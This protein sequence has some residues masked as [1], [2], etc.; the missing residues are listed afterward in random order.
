MLSIATPLWR[1]QEGFL[2]SAE[3]VLIATITILSMV[4]G[5]SEIAHGV[6]QELED[7]GTAF[8]VVNQNYRYSGVTG[9]KGALA[10]SGNRDYADYCDGDADIVCHLA[11]T[12]EY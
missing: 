11:V 12:G 3:L 2:V 6:N 1:D 4:V 8:G 10:G 5:L 9:H 7:I